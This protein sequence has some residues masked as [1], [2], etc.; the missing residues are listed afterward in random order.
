MKTLC[1]ILLVIALGATV[2]AAQTSIGWGNLQWPF[3]M[4]DPGCAGTGVFGQVWMDGVTSGV[5]QGA[6]ITAELG[7][8]PVGSTPDASWTW[9][10]ATFNV[11]VGNNDEFVVWMNSY[12]PFGTYDFTYRY[13]FAG[14]ADYYYAA[15]RGLATFT[16]A[17]GPVGDQIV[18]WGSLKSAY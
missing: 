18:T 9:L 7:F 16:T 12:L 17:C 1:T 6:G 3:E 8:G 2:A 4:T 11:D 5:G 13:L 14:D 15:E 10:P